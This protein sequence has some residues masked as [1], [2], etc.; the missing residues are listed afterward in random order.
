ML[1]FGHQTNKQTNKTLQRVTNHKVSDESVKVRWEKE[2]GWA[3]SWTTGLC[4]C[5]WS[6]GGTRKTQTLTPFEFFSGPYGAIT[7]T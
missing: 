1:A 7:K 3:S 2:L 4:S 6:N 5:G